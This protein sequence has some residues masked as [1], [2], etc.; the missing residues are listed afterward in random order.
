MATTDAEVRVRSQTFWDILNDAR[1]DEINDLEANV[2]RVYRPKGA[3]CFVKITKR[4]FGPESKEYLLDFARNKTDA[5]M[6][7]RLNPDITIEA[8]INPTSDYTEIV[9]RH[10]NKIKTDG[11]IVYEENNY[12]DRLHSKILKPASVSLFK[13]E[14][15]KLRRCGL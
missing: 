15:N 6:D 1:I 12:G 9:V 11:Y 3:D 4:D 13:V 2:D 5:P 7:I 10:H 14:L 8:R